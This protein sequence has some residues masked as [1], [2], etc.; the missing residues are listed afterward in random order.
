MCVFEQHLL[1]TWRRSVELLHVIHQL[2]LKNP[3]GSNR[4]GSLVQI[5]VR[6]HLIAWSNFQFPNKIQ[7]VASSQYQRWCACEFAA[8]LIIFRL[9]QTH[10]HVLTSLFQSQLLHVS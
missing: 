5:L 7:V 9:F 10:Q 8:P 3:P 2:Q 4:V 1:Q 6:D